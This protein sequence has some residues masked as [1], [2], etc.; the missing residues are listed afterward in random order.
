MGREK[1]RMKNG[2]GAKTPRKRIS[3]VA[4]VVSGEDKD[5]IPVTFAEENT[6][7]E[8]P[9]FEVWAE[10][11][12]TDDEV[13][14]HIDPEVQAGPHTCD[15]MSHIADTLSETV[16]RNIGTGELLELVKDMLDD[17]WQILW[18]LEEFSTEEI[19]A[20]IAAAEW[21]GDS[22]LGRLPPLGNRPSG[23]E[24]SETPN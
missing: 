20:A 18:D 4:V 10:A 13:I 23:D 2:S 8:E 6:E 3:R 21:E 5:G 14:K 7:E 16:P 15:D 22:S 9:A 24:M 17:L 19:N 11:Y 1:G 12:T